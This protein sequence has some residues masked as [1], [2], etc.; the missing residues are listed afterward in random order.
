MSDTDITDLPILS[1][2]RIEIEER[3]P[4]T[5]R[6]KTKYV[7]VWR[8]WADNDEMMVD[9]ARLFID[10]KNDR[11][12][13]PT[14][15]A[16]NFWKLV[17]PKKLVTHDIRIDGF[18]ATRMALPQLDVN[19]RP[20]VI[21]GV[22][23]F[24]KPKYRKGSFDVILLDFPYVSQGGRDTSTIPGM[25]EAYGMYDAPRTPE[26]VQALINAGMAAAK[27]LL[28][29]DDPSYLMVKTMGYVS[30]AHVFDS[31]RFTKEQ[32]EALGLTLV[33]EFV[34]SSGLP[35]PQPKTNLDGSPRTQQHG[36]FNFS[37]LLVF[38]NRRL[39][40]GKLLARQQRVA[41][42][43]EAL[44][45]EV[46]EQT[47]DGTDGTGAQV[48]PEPILTENSARAKV[49]SIMSEPRKKRAP[50]ATPAPSA[51]TSRHRGPKKVTAPSMP[52]PPVRRIKRILSPLDTGI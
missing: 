22:R 6:G 34:F 47:K 44:G 50:K 46:R 20:M 5:A 25:Q 7:K 29:E 8:P 27:P 3:P 13:D 11:V 17:R 42:L 51:P 1:F 24:Q 41:A 28:R 2:G 19:G 52:A 43:A 12:L 23:I 30:S 9:V 4:K 14:Y 49:Q 31:T 40:K 39:T 38:D 26:E 33:G 10:V 48:L 36:R 32:G 37:T 16:G 21:D 15:G 35:G 45:L 18:D